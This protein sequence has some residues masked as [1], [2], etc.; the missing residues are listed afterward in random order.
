MQDMVILQIS[1]TELK[2]LIEETI[3]DVFKTTPTTVHEDDSFLT[4]QEAANFLHLSVSTIYSLVS[5][6]K[7]PVM[8][9]S[10]RCY[11]S[12]KELLNYLKDGRRKTTKEMED[13]G[14]VF[15]DNFLKNQKK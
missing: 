5:K 10:K 1:P 8:K 15:V 6:K 14:V 3:R 7:L 13:D 12:K 4:V 9:R 11:F 2:I